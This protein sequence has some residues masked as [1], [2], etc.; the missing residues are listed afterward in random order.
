MIVNLNTVMPDGLVCPAGQRR[1]ELVDTG[2][3]GMYLEVRA[4]SPGQG[5]YYLRYK[6]TNGKTCHQKI[7]RTDDV[8]LEAARRQAKTL[9]AEIT[10][11]ADP[12]AE[13]KARKSVITF[14]EYFREHYL[15]HVKVH[16]RG[17]KK[18]SPM[19]NLRIKEVFGNKRLDQIKRHEISSW[20][21]SLRED[22]L[23]PAYAD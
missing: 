22:G 16:N 21:V 8:S 13:E 2:G 1:I 4:T 9:K 23:S 18:K 12:R 6:D 19:Y 3:T 15:P 5:T 17:W 10:L 14:D 7:G 20:H 11:G